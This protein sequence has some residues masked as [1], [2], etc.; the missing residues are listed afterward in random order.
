MTKLKSTFF[1]TAAI[2][3]VSVAT[4]T[5]SFAQDQTGL[6]QVQTGKMVDTGQNAISTAYDLYAYGTENN[7]ALA[8]IAAAKIIATTP[9]S[10]SEIEV[11]EKVEDG[12]DTTEEADK[13]TAPTTLEDM[14]ATASKLAG[15]N[16]TYKGLIEDVKAEQPRGRLRGPG[17]L[18]K[19]LLAGRTHIIRDTFEGGSLAQVTLIGDGD[20]N[21]DMVVLDQNGNTVCKDRSYSDKLRCSWYPRWTG[22]FSIGIRNQGRIRNTYVL[23][24]N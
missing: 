2:V 15:D 17:R 1:A 3:A 4:P 23:L 21:L 22:T 20:T 9:V 18:V 14:L 6:N 8:V 16:E 24:T 10:D 7:D 13:T 11:E 5:L 19:G 12:A